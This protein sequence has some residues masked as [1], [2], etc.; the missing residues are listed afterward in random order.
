MKPLAKLI[1]ISLFLVGC[2][3]KEERFVT[4]AAK[5]IPQTVMIYCAVEV[6]VKGSSEPARGVVQGAG[7]FISANNH[8]LTCA[9]LFWL[10]KVVGTTVCDSEGN[11]TAADLLYKE[12]NRD[13]ALIQAFYDKPHSY[14]RIADPRKLKVGQ[15]VIAV[16]NPL[17]LDFSVCHGI[18][19]AL[20]RDLDPMY[21]MTQSDAMI[22]PGNSGGPLFNLKGELV[23]INRRVLPQIPFLHINTGLGFSIQ[24]GQIIEFLTKFRGIDSSIPTFNKKYWEFEV[25]R[26]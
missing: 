23:G 24:S 26:S 15:E 20:N 13:L 3:T 22:N 11:C 16:G 17:G 10:G 25:H 19:S 7:V 9:H 6:N 8:I 2:S 18:I 1:L 5:A 21:N 14:P 12:D 4:V